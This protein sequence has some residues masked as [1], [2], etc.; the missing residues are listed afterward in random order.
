M[1]PEKIEAEGGAGAM[2]PPVPV[3]TAGFY[4]GLRG[5]GMGHAGELAS[6]VRE[7]QS[8]LLVDPRNFAAWNNMGNIFASLKDWPTARIFLEQAETISPR[9]ASVLNN[10]ANV[11]EQ[12]GESE[13][14][15]EKRRSAVELE[16][17]NPQFRNNLGNSLRGLK[18][19]AAAEEML[20]SALAVREDY[21]AAYVNLAYLF[22]EQGKLEEAERLYRIAIVLDPEYALAHTCLGQLLLYRGYFREGWMEQEWRWRWGDFP[23]PPRS[24][25]QPL[26]GGEEVRGRRVLLHAEQG[27]G[28]AI[29]F[30]RYVPMVAALGAHVI[31]EVHPEL[32]GVMDSVAGVSELVARG[33]ALPEFDVHCPL[34]SLP[35]VFDT[36]LETIPGEVPYLR[37]VGEAPLWLD[38]SG[39]KGKR[40]GVVWAGNPANRVDRRRSI[41]VSELREVLS[42]EGVEFYSF[43]RGGGSEEE[44]A[45]LGFDGALPE[46]GDFQATAVALR[47]MDM[48]ISVDTAVA[49]MAG[50]LGLPVWIVLPFVADWRW[51]EDGTGS[52]WY[53]GARLFR[54][55]EDRRWDG[56]IAR[57]RR[58]L[59]EWVG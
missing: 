53:P 19:W 9:N 43:Q 50:A 10:L 33:D 34:L 23:S 51:M 45:G 25:E 1:T 18:D 58:E 38:G 20:N 5:G 41:A 27:F 17:E 52:P 4:A 22:Y 54:Q 39:R 55:G 35:Y 11:L 8:V 14:S 44:I 31:L 28:D 29:Q 49:H 59:V 6:A 57:V 16:P 37:A 21:P 48:L 26:W 2:S 46:T 42:V 12:C 32:V 7:Y 36:T 30:A 13:R 40:V 24:F 15:A 3:R 47:E 56:V